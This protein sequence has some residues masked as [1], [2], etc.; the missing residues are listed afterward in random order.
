MKDTYPRHHSQ[1]HSISNSS[2]MLMKESSQVIIYCPVYYHGLTLISGWINNHMSCKLW[3]EIINPFPNS[4]TV[5]VW[6]CTSNFLPYFIMYAIIYPCW[7]YS[8]TMLVKWAPKVVRCWLTIPIPNEIMVDE[9]VVLSNIPEQIWTDWIKF[10]TVLHPLKYNNLSWNLFFRF[11]TL[12][13]TDLWYKW[14]R[15][16]RLLFAFLQEI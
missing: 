2:M 14:N 13:R 3:D 15:I 7:D 5:E 9:T 16:G 4:C 1:Y 8:Q 12:C 10:L 11:L 6:E